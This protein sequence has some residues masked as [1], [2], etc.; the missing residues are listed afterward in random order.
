[1]EFTRSDPVTPIE[2]CRRNTDIG[3]RILL[4]TGEKSE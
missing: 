1:M 4:R 2:H 3:F